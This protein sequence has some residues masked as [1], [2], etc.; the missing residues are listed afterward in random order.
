MPGSV[1]LFH[2]NALLESDYA[3]LP[4]IF[5]FIALC[6][7]PKEGGAHGTMPPPKYAPGCAFRN[8]HNILVTA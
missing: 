6:R 5:H 2:M 4:F 1:S 3:I 8:G 7:G